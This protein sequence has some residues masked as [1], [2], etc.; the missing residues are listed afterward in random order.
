MFNSW[1]K[2][3]LYNINIY[4]SFV[5]FLKWKARRVIK[6]SVQ[7]FG[8]TLKSFRTWKA[9]SKHYENFFWF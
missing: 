6:E 9:W 7:K 1:I 4:K 8:K 5:D 2:F 3:I